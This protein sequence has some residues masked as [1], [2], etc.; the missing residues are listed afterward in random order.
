M[1]VGSLLRFLALSNRSEP[2]VISFCVRH[3]S[4]LEREMGAVELGFWVFV[5][6]TVFCYYSDVFI[7]VHVFVSGLVCRVDGIRLDHWPLEFW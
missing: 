5:L 6:F 3:G 2:G 4:R 7:L 1:E